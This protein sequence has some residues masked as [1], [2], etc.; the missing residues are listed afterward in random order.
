MVLEQFTASLSIVFLSN[1]FFLFFATVSFFGYL[2]LNKLFL[3]NQVNNS[4]LLVKFSLILVIFVFCGS[5][6]NFFSPINDFLVGMLYLIGFIIFILKL[7]KKENIIELKWILVFFLLITLYLYDSGNNNDFDYHSKHIE[8]YKNYSLLNFNQNIID[9]RVKYNSIYLLLNSLTYLTNI[10]ISIKFLSAFIFGLFILDIKKLIEK[11]ENTVAIKY[12]S[13]FTLICFFLALSKYKNIG[14]D[15]S[16]HLIYI[17]LIIFYFIN[18]KLNKKLFESTEFFLIL[19]LILSLLVILKISMILCSLILF[20]YIFI[21]YQKQKI[22]SLFS[23]Y[24]FFPLS[25]VLIWFFQNY[26]LSK[27]IVFPLAPLCFL[28]ENSL[29]SVIFEHN[30]INLFAKS[31]KINYWSEPISVLREMNSISYWI[32]FW[33]HD[34]FLKI[35]EKFLPAMV[36]LNIFLFK[37]FVRS[38]RNLQLVDHQTLLFLIIFV[39][40]FIWFLQTPAMRFGFSYLILIFF[41]L[42]I[43]ILK[44]F[45]LGLYDHLEN[46]YF[47]RTFNFIIY[48]MIIY[49]FIRIYSY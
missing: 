14:T 23:I 49:Q 42:N 12:F 7:L 34:H 13:I 39:I 26:V 27:C 20:H 15:Y 25:L 3:L 17:S 44:L 9:G 8:L 41:A 35:L 29:K 48:L 19:C 18:C 4:F 37:L 1:L 30:M 38:K 16:A 10:F 47:S 22:L 5:I 46:N 6:I 28:D 33:L 45:N 21:I 36:L 31:V 40:L 2:S 32:P 43:G 24:L 11:K